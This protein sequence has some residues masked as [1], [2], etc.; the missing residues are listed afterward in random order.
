MSAIS[1][2]DA[3]EAKGFT[4]YLILGLILVILG[5][6]SHAYNLYIA[7]ENEQLSNQYQQDFAQYQRDNVYFSPLNTINWIE[8]R[9]NEN[10]Y[11]VTNPDLINEP[12]QYNQN[13]LRAT[14][15]AV[16]TLAQLNG[17]GNISEQTVLDFLESRYHEFEQNNVKLAGFS[18]LE[19]TEV[20]VRTTMDAILTLKHLDAFDK[21]NIDWDAVRRFILKHQNSDGGFWDPHYPKFGTTSCLKCTSFALRAL[22]ALNEFEGKH[23]PKSF[24]QKVIHYVKA[25][26]DKNRDA[27]SARL[28]VEAEDSYDIFRAF[29][30]FWNLTNGNAELKRNLVLE[31]FP[32]ESV[33][34]TLQAH[35]ITKD[36]AYARKWDAQYP[37]MKAT[38]LMVW[39]YYNLGM[40]D[41]LDRNGIIDFVFIN[42]KNPG[43]YGGDI[44]NTYSA[45]GILT[46][47]DI[48]TEPL[49]PPQEPQL[50]HSILPNFLPY[51][52]YILAL[53]TTLIY[54]NK[55]KRKLIDK[56]LLLENKAFKDKLTG[57][58]NR[59]FIERAYQY[60]Q[61]TDEVLSL[62]LIDID[63]FKVINDNHGH[64]IGDKV[65]QDFAKLL[66]TS[67]RSSDTLARWGGEEF[68]LLCPYTDMSS[69]IVLA[70]KLREIV[71]LE[72]FENIGKLTASFGISA[73]EQDDSWMQ[74]FER[75]D[76]AVYQSKQAGRNQVS[77]I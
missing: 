3:Q 47:L 68:A 13:S 31:Q 34:E 27:Y 15:Y 10:G 42:E 33:E 43:E 26:W 58:H 21:L 64:L 49:S 66:Q 36:R 46:K 62:I 44:Y 12:S 23:F 39:M 18:T 72:D 76:K 67:L 20:A 9:Q 65:L 22:G 25:S 60:H 19:N 61:E 35:F 14:R 7:S 28:G 30:I 2:S 55:D 74:L 63:N 40:L 71:A 37:S 41:R 45:T 57:L 59:E 56:N 5:L 8:I 52:L 17:V 11:F 1:N 53:A 6:A 54:F 50:Q 75:A 70:E 73:R 24:Q 77:H 16:T 51:L 69:A 38:H 48:N 29:I 32:L 4:N